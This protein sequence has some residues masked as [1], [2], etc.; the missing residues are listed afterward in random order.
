MDD[1]P[2]LGVAAIIIVLLVGGGITINME[3][4]TTQADR[5][6][7]AIEGGESNE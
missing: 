5:I 3:H 7:A 1:N 4:T 2:F 6:I